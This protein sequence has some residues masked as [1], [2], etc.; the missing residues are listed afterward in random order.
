MTKVSRSAAFWFSIAAVAFVLLVVLRHILLP[1]VIGLTLAYLLAPLV[2]TFDRRGIN[3]AFATLTIMLLVVA[4][5]VAFTVVML[6]ALVGEVTAFVEALPRYLAHIQTLA[7]DANH[8]WMRKIVGHE[9][10]FDQPSTP[11]ISGAG[12]HWFG[13]VLSSLWSGGNALLSLVS[14]LVVAPIVA[15]YVTIDWDK[16]ITT[17]DAWISPKH[18]DEVR[19]LGRE[20]NDTV[21]GFVRGQTVICLVLV[22]FYATVLRSVGLHHGIAIGLIAGLIS[23]VPYLG[24]GTFGRAGRQS[25][26]LAER[27]LSEKCSLT[28]CWRRA[29]LDAV[30][31]STQSG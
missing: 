6:P 16:M 12:G 27:S 29:S 28:M 8:P 25:L 18:R 3:R 23:F 10:S 7:A 20:I 13:D 15:I 19:A 5:F 17:V 4:G 21:A 2:S 1:F 26:S 9:L 11:I 14:L 22:L 24:A 31:S 30:S